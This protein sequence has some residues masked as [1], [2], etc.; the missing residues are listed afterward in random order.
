M[1]S[2]KGTEDDLWRKETDVALR[3]VG[4]DRLSE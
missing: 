3:Q 4:T 2:L 1:F